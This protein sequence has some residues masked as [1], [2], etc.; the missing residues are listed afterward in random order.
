MKPTFPIVDCDWSHAARTIRRPTPGR[1]A[2]PIMKRVLHEPLVHFLFAGGLLFA[3]YAWL[4]RDGGNVKGVVRLTEADVEWLAQTWG[5]QWQRPPTDEELRGL[6]ADYLKEM[7]LA[8]EAR[9]LGLDENDT[10][11]RRRL[12]QKMQFLV[13]DT[14][15]LAEPSEDELH[16]YYLANV[17]RYQVPAH[18]SFTQVYFKSAA[19]A[20]LGLKEL[21]I[22]DASELGDT[23]LLE[24]VHTGADDQA[25]ASLFGPEFAGVVFA[26][27]PGRWH[28]PIESAYGFHLVWISDR[29]AAHSRSFDQVRANVLDDWHREQQAA[30][31]EQFLGALMMKYTVIADEKIK[32]LIGPRAE[33]VR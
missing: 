26:L 29:Q 21:A 23:S 3:A 2:I 15:R 22:V 14:A 28:G 6:V 16:R 13:E 11:V 9:D 4:G 8:R 25:V 1:M 17:W 5:R 27:E 30:I 10:I 7:L 32:P 31:A 19:A 12:A 20:Q 33:A 24:R 18:V